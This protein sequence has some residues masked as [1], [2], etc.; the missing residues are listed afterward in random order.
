M[1]GKNAQFL[2]IAKRPFLKNC[3]EQWFSTE[4]VCMYEMRRDFIS[5]AI[6][7]EILTSGKNFF[8]F[9]CQTIA[10]FNK[11]HTLWFKMSTPW[12]GPIKN[13]KKR[14]LTWNKAKNMQ[15]L[16]EKSCCT[17]DKCD[18]NTFIYGSFV[19]LFL[20]AI[21]EAVTRIT[22]HRHK[23]FYTMFVVD[24]FLLS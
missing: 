21:W 4:S 8:T 22:P 13:S 3:R 23:T 20:S 11:S 7:G 14:H 15:S 6:F 16:F 18:N 2:R 24:L 5:Y 10:A 19:Y 17:Y 9:P 12:K 1:A